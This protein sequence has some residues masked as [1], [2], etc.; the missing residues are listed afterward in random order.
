MAAIRQ[1][2]SGRE[3]NLVVETADREFAGIGV[4]AQFQDVYTYFGT[5]PLNLGPVRPDPVTVLV[6][7]EVRLRRAVSIIRG[8]LGPRGMGAV[9]GFTLVERVDS[10]SMRAEMPVEIQADGEVLGRFTQLSARFAHHALKIAVP[11]SPD[12]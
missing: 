12:R 5:R 6:V 7:E 9:K 4:M 3:S 11:Q 8:A 10:F 2:L 1:D